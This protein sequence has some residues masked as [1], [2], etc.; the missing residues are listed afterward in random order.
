MKIKI[1][2]A[3]CIVAIIIG[4]TKTSASENNPV[5]PGQSAI[6]TGILTNQLTPTN[7]AVVN[8]QNWLYLYS[9]V[10]NDVITVSITTNGFIFLSIVGTNDTANAVVLSQFNLFNLRTGTNTITYYM[11]LSNT[12]NVLYSPTNTYTLIRTF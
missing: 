3:L 2:I 6:T 10:S 11:I 9:G 1:T 4:C 7:G 8:N 5:S 12:N